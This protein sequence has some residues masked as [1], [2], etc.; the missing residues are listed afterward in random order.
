M[1]FLKVFYFELQNFKKFPL[2]NKVW[3]SVICKNMVEI[4]H[5]KKFEKYRTYILVQA[6]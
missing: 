2:F 5:L 3:K 4:I 6:L 1:L